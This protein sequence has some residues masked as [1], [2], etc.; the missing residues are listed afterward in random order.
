[1]K[2]EL[3]FYSFD[4][5]TPSDCGN[6]LD[7][8]FSSHALPWEGVILEKGQ[9]PHFYPQ[10]VFT[11]YFYFALALDKEL[12]WNVKSGE[13]LTSIKAVTDD[14]WINPPNTPFTHDIS[15]P[16]HFVI[17]A[18]E[19]KQ[20]L[21]NCPLNIS[22]L[23]L[24]FLNNYNVSD[25]TIKGI[26]DLFIM[27]VKSNGRN[28]M[29]YL[30]SLLSLLSGYY[31]QNYSNYQDLQ[32]AR[33]SNSKLGSDQL[34]KIDRYIDEN[35]GAPI[36]IDDFADLLHCSKFYFLR[37]FKKLAGVTPY[38]YLMNKRLEQAKSALQSGSA[39]LATLSNE[40][41]FNDQSHFTR[42]FKAHFGVTPG[43]YG[44]R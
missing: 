22:K 20:L 11:P 12:T 24:T 4:S 5:K 19:E 16:C 8:E 43:Q 10:N 18:I 34:D 39:N 42:T 1:M 27:E 6:V 29:S 25:P 32:N 36:S 41:G 44:K 30:K 9:S 13:N 2:S 23:D 40:L 33:L 26:M 28:G 17:L 37:E 3:K 15:E 35:I 38:Q 21:D 14:I 31:I 7:I